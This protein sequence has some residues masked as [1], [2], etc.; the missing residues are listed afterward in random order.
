MVFLFFICVVNRAVIIGNRKQTSPLS[1]LLILFKYDKNV[2]HIRD[3]FL[4]LMHMTV[5]DSH[6]TW[7]S[8]QTQS[9]YIM[10]TNCKS[11]VFLFTHHTHSL[12]I[13]L[14][15]YYMNVREEACF[16]LLETRYRQ[17]RNTK[18]GTVVTFTRIR[19][20]LND[21]NGNCRRAF[22]TICCLNSIARLHSFSFSFLDIFLDDYRIGMVHKR[23][24]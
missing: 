6:I 13:L 14:L 3:I 5:N 22:Y 17:R 11:F 15:L 7:L 1:N 10:S 18:H 16:C 2:Y 20:M 8:T 9:H 19:R 4:C 21:D 23:G 12:A 24:F